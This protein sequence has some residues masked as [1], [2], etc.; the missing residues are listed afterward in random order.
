MWLEEKS[1]LDNYNQKWNLGF[2]GEDEFDV[3]NEGV[4][5]LRLFETYQMCWKHLLIRAEDQGSLLNLS[6]VQLREVF[7]CCFRNSVSLSHPLYEMLVS[8]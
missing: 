2:R 6:S 4:H 5:F 7:P 3:K 8:T 1:N